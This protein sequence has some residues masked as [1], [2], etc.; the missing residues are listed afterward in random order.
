MASGAGD[1]YCK[2]MRTTRRKAQGTGGSCMSEIALNQVGMIVASSPPVT[3]LTF[4]LPDIHIGFA[5]IAER[6]YFLGL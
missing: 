4:L 6:F 1:S 3:Q 2:Q 5:Y